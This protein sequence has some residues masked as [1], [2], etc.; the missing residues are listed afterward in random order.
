MIEYEDSP[1]MTVAP[2]YP[3]IYSYQL[4]TSVLSLPYSSYPPLPTVDR[5]VVST[6]FRIDTDS[7][8]GVYESYSLDLDMPISNVSPNLHVRYVVFPIVPTLEN[9]LLKLLVRSLTYVLEVFESNLQLE[10]QLDEITLV[11]GSRWLYNVVRVQVYH[12]VLHVRHVVT[13]VDEDLEYYFE[14]Y[15]SEWIDRSDR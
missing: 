5:P 14:P 1:S 13:K 9:V 11:H 10:A 12:T 7:Y 2:V 4:S 6:L 3:T 8:D 15:E